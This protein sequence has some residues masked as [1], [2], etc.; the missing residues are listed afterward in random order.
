MATVIN[1]IATIRSTAT[2][3]TPTQNALNV[4]NS[5]LRNRKDRYAAYGNP[6][7][8][9]KILRNTTIYEPLFPRMKEGKKELEEFKSVANTES[10]YAG[11]NDDLT[12]IRDPSEKLNFIRRIWLVSKDVT[13]KQNY[14]DV[15]GNYQ[16]ILK[17]DPENLKKSDY[18]LFAIPTERKKTWK[19]RL[20]PFSNY[21]RFA[22]IKM[23]RNNRNRVR[24]DLTPDAIRNYQL[25]A[26]NELIGIM[27]ILMEKARD[28]YTKDTLS[29]RLGFRK[30]VFSR[31]DKEGI[32]HIDKLQE[33]YVMQIF[34]YDLDN[35]L[36]DIYSFFKMNNPHDQ[37]TFINFLSNPNVQ[38]TLAAITYIV[39]M[40]ALFGRTKT[41]SHICS[42]G[43][44]LSETLVPYIGFTVGPSKLK[45]KS[46]YWCTAANGIQTLAAEIPHYTTAILTVGAM[47]AEQ[48]LSLALAH[49]IPTAIIV[50]YKLY[51]MY[52]GYKRKTLLKEIFIDIHKVIFNPDNN[53]NFDDAKEF[54]FVYND[55]LSDKERE[56]FD[57]YGPLI[58]ND[59]TDQEMYD[60]LT[61]FLQA[62]TDSLEEK[63][64]LA[65]EEIKRYLNR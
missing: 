22:T 41:K 25:N 7:K 5:T 39:I 47:T 42:D 1:P 26:Y 49:G 13:H 65:A 10:N 51:K 16:R 27:I 60:Y 40:L 21:T 55:I 14:D 61:E 8:A 30:S 46:E 15:I 50:S 3:T 38:K 11:N 24:N 52:R 59:A 4:S 29:S 19:N 23:T 34:G 45:Y 9:T 20:N 33:A 54:V 64:R 18:N 62:R 12:R 28:K 2:R 53:M 58:D 48:V 36:R 44:K 57:E 31:E 35:Q 63:A 56:I 32:M 37:V 6:V 17:I 43:S